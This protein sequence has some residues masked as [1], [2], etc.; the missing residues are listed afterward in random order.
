MGTQANEFVA[1]AFRNAAESFSKTVS[2]GIE[3]QEQA[4]KFWSD[5]VNKTTEQFRKQADQVSSDA[6]PA[7]KKNLEQFHNMFDQQVNNCLD[8]LRE[9][10]DAGK[11]L[12]VQTMRD[13]TVNLWRTSF[14][15]MRSNIDVMTKANVETFE[16]FC[17]MSKSCSPNGQK[18]ATKT[19]GK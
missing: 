1:D 18:A 8:T 14:D 17:E 15:A 12:D 13:Q 10:F 2:T 7:A 11:E 19:S 5:T 3:F 4:A 16:K 9:T 6:I